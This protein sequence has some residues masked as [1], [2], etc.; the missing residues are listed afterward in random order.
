MF[1]GLIEEVGV[2]AEVLGSPR[3]QD[4]VIRAPLLAPRLKLGDSLAVDGVCL[5][6]TGQSDAKVRLEAVG[7][8]LEKSTLPR[9]KPGRPVNLERPLSPEKLLDGHLVLGH[10]TGTSPILAFEADAAGGGA[11]PQAWFLTIE[12]HPS[13]LGRIAQEGSIALDGISLTVAKLDL[14]SQPARATVSVIPHTRAAT[15]LKSK[16]I[17]EEVNVELDIL[18]TYIF[19][20]VSALSK[21]G[22]QASASA[23]PP[24]SEDILRSWGYK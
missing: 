18:A 13:W 12:V 4:L 2:L 7:S 21:G 16:A 20:A 22:R 8:T 23:S 17:G 9:Y 15:T 5:T 1:T 14:I 11:G 19:S 10:V 24:F 3:G 6:V